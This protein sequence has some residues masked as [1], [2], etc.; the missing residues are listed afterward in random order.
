MHGENARLR[1]RMQEMN[2]KFELLLISDHKQAPQP[3]V[4]QLPA[5]PQEEDPEPIV[6]DQP[7][8][9]HPTACNTTN[10]EKQ[11]GTLSVELEPGVKRRALLTKR[12]TSRSV[13]ERIAWLEEAHKQHVKSTNKRLSALEATVADLVV[14]VSN[15]EKIL[16]QIQETLQKL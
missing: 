4:M 7:E 10:D 16:S 5:P 13:E 14:R 2:R 1:E 6:E 9:S 11:D 12:R 3:S 15:T 8:R